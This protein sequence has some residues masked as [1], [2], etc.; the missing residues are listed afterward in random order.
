MLL[1][2]K[3]YPLLDWRGTWSLRLLLQAWPI[4]ITGP[5][6][7]RQKIDKCLLDY[8]L[9]LCRTLGV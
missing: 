2:G 7:M 5:Y 1:L 6:V 9:K 3:R 8:A 4:I